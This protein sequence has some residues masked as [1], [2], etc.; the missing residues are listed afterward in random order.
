M[1]KE[2]IPIVH[3]GRAAIL[4]YKEDYGFLDS[5]GSGCPGG[6]VGEG[7]DK[8][9]SQLHRSIKRKVIEIRDFLEGRPWPCTLK[10]LPFHLRQ[11]LGPSWWSSCL[12]A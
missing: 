6:K 4:G 12:W 2:I 8:P 5:S 11:L 3:L 1:A 10:W 7:C 9:T